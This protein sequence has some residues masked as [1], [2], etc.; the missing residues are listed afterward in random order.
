MKPDSIGHSLK[1]KTKNQVK[2]IM[3]VSL[4]HSDFGVWRYELTKNWFFRREM[5]LFFAENTVMDIVITDYFL[6]NII[7]ENIY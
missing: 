1:D 4:Y 5:I 2:E 3:G 7:R 6:G